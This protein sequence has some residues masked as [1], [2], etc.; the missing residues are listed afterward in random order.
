MDRTE[1]LTLS[2]FNFIE[3][4]LDAT[5]R[6]T[7]SPFIYWASIHTLQQNQLYQ[8][9]DGTILA[10]IIMLTAVTLILNIF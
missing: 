4:N 10:S 3:K 7:L 8:K 1:R 6:L 9:K 2:L 5:E